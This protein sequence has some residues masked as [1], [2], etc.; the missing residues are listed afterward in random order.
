MK[1]I[2]MFAA[3]TLSSSVFA[4]GTALTAGPNSTSISTTACTA[5]SEAVKV[6]LSKS[7]VGG[8][9]CDTASI[10]VG[11][12]NIAGKGR[13]FSS[14]SAGGSITDDACAATICVEGDATG[15]ATA[16]L[17]RANAS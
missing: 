10:G 7:N 15:K 12:A 5:L 4:A 17:A 16:A 13:V 2:L 9:E 11:V 8:Y 14:N 3:M 6:N 1:K